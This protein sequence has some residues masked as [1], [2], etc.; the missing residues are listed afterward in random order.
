MKKDEADRITARI[1]KGEDVLKACGGSHAR[2]MQWIRA[3][4]AAGLP[5]SARGLREAAASA[6]G[7]PVP[8]DIAPSSVGQEMPQRVVVVAPP[9]PAE[10][11][12]DPL[13]PERISQLTRGAVEI[14][15]IHAKEDPRW[16]KILQDYLKLLDPDLA[17]RRGG[18]TPAAFAEE[19]ER[20]R[21]TPRPPLMTWEEAHGQ[22]EAQP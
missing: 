17:E 15:W 12:A 3:R 6:Q 2:R 9:A 7:I 18:C 14:A 20:I 8:R 11:P 21:S 22:Q 4:K 13:T 1:L 19:W 16:A 5:E 10:I